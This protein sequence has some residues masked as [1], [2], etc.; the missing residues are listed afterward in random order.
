MKVIVNPEPRFIEAIDSI[1][2][3]RR[4]VAGYV[5]VRVDDAGNVV[6]YW[7]NVSHEAEPAE[8]PLDDDPYLF[9]T[10]D[11]AM[12]RVQKMANKME[13]PRPHVAAWIYP[14]WYPEQ[15]ALVRNIDITRGSQMPGHTMQGPETAQMPYLG[16]QL[17]SKLSHTKQ[18]FIAKDLS[19]PNRPGELVAIYYEDWDSGRPVV[20][21]WRGPRMD[22]EDFARTGLEPYACQNLLTDIGGYWECF[23]GIVIGTDKPPLAPSIERETPKTCPLCGIKYIGTPGMHKFDCPAQSEDAQGGL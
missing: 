10:P 12:V 3:H 19:L 14:D 21:G 23:S 18:F 13:F 11:R 9:S 17:M 4:G 20:E 8:D 5:A 15:G 1:R 16:G 22:S 6:S 7:N 2:L